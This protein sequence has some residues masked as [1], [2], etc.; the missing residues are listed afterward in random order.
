MVTNRLKLLDN[1]GKLSA[2][3]CVLSSLT[4]PSPGLLTVAANFGRFAGRS[5]ESKRSETLVDNDG[6]G[7][8]NFFVAGRG[9]VPE[10]GGKEGR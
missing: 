7:T 1:N 4:R 2:S 5:D 8:V 9:P 10:R 3:L 6:V